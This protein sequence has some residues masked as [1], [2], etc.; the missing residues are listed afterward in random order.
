MQQL[1]QHL[2]PAKLLLMLGVYCWHTPTRNTGTMGTVHLV[3]HHMALPR[4]F[5]Q[6]TTET[7][8]VRMVAGK[9]HWKPL[10]S[11]QI[12]GGVCLLLGTRCPVPTYCTDG[13]AGQMT[14]TTK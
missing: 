5:Q 14:A 1:Q 11:Q 7:T 13:S 12:G 9:L 3:V 10:Q 2:V 6:M 8:S 4:S